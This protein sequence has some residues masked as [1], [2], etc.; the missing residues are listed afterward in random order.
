MKSHPVTNDGKADTRY[1]IEREFCGHLE[2]R[3]VARFCGEW[4]GQSKFY[5]AAVMLAVGHNCQRKGCAII[6]SA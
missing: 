5:S 3:F 4:I 6:V 1:E 2:K